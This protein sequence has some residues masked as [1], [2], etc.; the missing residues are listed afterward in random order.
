[1]KDLDP[2]VCLT[3]PWPPR[4]CS[5]FCYAAS[6]LFLYASEPYSS[7]RLV[8]YRGTSEGADEWA[9][10][11]THADDEGTGAGGRDD[12]DGVGVNSIPKLDEVERV[13]I[14]AGLEYGSYGNR[15]NVAGGL[16]AATGGVDIPGSIEATAGEREVPRGIE[17]GVEAVSTGVVDV[18][19][20]V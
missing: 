12:D 8:Y 17:A 5:R 16:E 19:S 9:G 11:I 2:P 4:P 15:V 7:Q 10:A 18:S 6:L 13:D 20:L 14:G 1:M 3:G